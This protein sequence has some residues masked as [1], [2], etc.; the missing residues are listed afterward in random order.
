MPR[1][2]SWTQNKDRIQAEYVRYGSFYLT[3][4]PASGTRLGQK[5]A[6][7]SVVD[8]CPHLFGQLD[9]DPDW[10]FGSGSRRAK[11]THKSMF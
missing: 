7:R 4:L 1:H 11:M 5:A 6:E 3:F 2:C 10:E 9:P 8:P